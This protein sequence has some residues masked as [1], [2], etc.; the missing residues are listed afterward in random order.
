MATYTITTTAAEEI[1]LTNVMASP[2]DWA[3]NALS[4]R[5]R[6]AGNKIVADL[7]EHCNANSIALAVGRDAQII[8][9][10]T[11]GLVHDAS[12]NHVHE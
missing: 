11:L 6:I 2:E 5:A 4:E 7:V 1:C 8:Q 10:N 3:Q 9:A 12:T